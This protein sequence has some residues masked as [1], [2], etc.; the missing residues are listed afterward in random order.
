MRLE[1]GLEQKRK[2]LDS[3]SR[4][5]RGRVL[6]NH[7]CDPHDSGSLNLLKTDDKARG[8]ARRSCGSWDSGLGK[9]HGQV[10]MVAVDLPVDGL[11]RFFFFK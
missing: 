7:G 8:E 6:G 1:L 9:K 2:T 5:T 4:I 3:I 10:S 11:L